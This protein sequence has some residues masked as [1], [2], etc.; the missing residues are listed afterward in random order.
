MKLIKGNVMIKKID[1]TGNVNMYAVSN[2]E[3]TIFLREKHVIV[4][5]YWRP[6]NGKGMGYP[7]DRWIF[8]VRPYSKNVKQNQEKSKIIIEDAV[9]TLTLPGTVK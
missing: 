5:G 3:S 6:V 7:S 2:S 4:D 9:L 8:H 1:W